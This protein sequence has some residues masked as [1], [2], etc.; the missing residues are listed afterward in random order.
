MD[1]LTQD[2]VNYMFS[3][4]NSQIRTKLNY[5]TAYNQAKKKYGKAFLD[6]L[7]I[8]EISPKNLKYKK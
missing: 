8:Q 3:I 6:D 2:E 1:N 4:I 7:G 5:Q